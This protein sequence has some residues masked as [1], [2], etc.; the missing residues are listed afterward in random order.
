MNRFI[1]ICYSK[2]YNLIAG[3]SLEMYKDKIS[4]YAYVIAEYL[5]THAQYK[6]C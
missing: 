2:L 5:N 3:Q 4:K 1:E 6:E